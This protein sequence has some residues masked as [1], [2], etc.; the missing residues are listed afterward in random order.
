MVK[1]FFCGIAQTTDS[2]QLFL[3]FYF[4]QIV[5][6]F[7]DFSVHFFCVYNSVHVYL[8]KR[9]LKPSNVELEKKC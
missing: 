1:P 8:N 4:L 6:F 9:K 2:V 3:L 5:L 7:Q